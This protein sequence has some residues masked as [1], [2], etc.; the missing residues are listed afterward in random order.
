MKGT[1]MPKSVNSARKVS[2][3]DTERVRQLHALVADI[4]PTARME[5]CALSLPLR[6]AARY[7]KGPVRRA[8]I[9]AAKRCAQTISTADD[10][11]RTALQATEAADAAV[12]VVRALCSDDQDDSPFEWTAEI[13]GCAAEAAER[14]AWLVSSITAECD[15]LKMPA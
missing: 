15:M 12:E 8:L 1:L 6:T 4:L 13:A 10:L 2:K 7:Q 3:R 11:Y 14:V 9:A 5:I